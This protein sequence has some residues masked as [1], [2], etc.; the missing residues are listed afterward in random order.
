VRGLTP[1]ELRAVS[2]GAGPL[3]VDFPYELE[4]E[5]HD[6]TR[7]GLMRHWVGDDETNYW[8]TTSLGLA[9]LKA[10]TEGVA[11]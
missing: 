11:A 5:I 7:R 4:A 3:D 9:I 2:L 1:D 6:L 10:C 8:Q